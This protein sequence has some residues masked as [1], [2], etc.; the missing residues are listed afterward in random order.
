MSPALFAKLEAKLRQWVKAGLSTAEINQLLLQFFEANGVSGF[1]PSRPQ[2]LVR[3]T[4][5]ESSLISKS[6]REATQLMLTT[7]ANQFARQQGKI[8]EGIVKEVQIGYSQG[9]NTKDLTDRLINNLGQ[10][11]AHAQTIARTANISLVRA[12]SVD[13]AISDGVEYFEYMGPRNTKRNFCKNRL[14]KT[15]SVDEIRKMSNRQLDPVLYYCG[16]YNCRH[17]WVPSTFKLYQ[18]RLQ[19]ENRAA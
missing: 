17:R 8:I 16:G 13:R 10:K 11:K 15:F 4:A 18:Q 5:I 14:G 1:N 7:A 2:D 3:N 12:G 9:L 19:L 6:S